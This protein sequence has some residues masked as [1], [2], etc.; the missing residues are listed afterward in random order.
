MR[1]KVFVAP[2]TNVFR[3]DPLMHGHKFRVLL[4]EHRRGVKVLAMSEAVLRELP[5]QFREQLESA[6]SKVQKGANT[7]RDLGIDLGKL[8]IPATQ[9]ASGQY[10]QRLREELGARGVQIEPIPDRN[11]EEF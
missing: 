2:D 9:L 3:G 7:L 11:V 4:G 6:A 8:P 5:R 1:A 10:E